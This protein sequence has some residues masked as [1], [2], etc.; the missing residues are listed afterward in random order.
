MINMTEAGQGLDK[1]IKVTKID[2]ALPEQEEL[3][4]ELHDFLQWLK[5]M[6][7]V[8]TTGAEQV[9]NGLDTVNVMRE[10]HVRQGNLAELQEAA[11]DFAGGFYMVPPIIE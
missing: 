1:A 4:R 11:P 10:D 5:P 6:L 9:L 3:E 8:D 7:A 2:V